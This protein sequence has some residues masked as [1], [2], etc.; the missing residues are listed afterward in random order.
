[1]ETQDP[2]RDLGTASFSLRTL[3]LLNGALL[4]ALS[5]SKDHPERGPRKRLRGGKM[6]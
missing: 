1:M 2:H 5:E 6:R 4:Q 3:Y